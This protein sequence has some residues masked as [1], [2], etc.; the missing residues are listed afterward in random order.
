MQRVSYMPALLLAL[1]VAA[2]CQ[3]S[4][5]GFVSCRYGKHVAAFSSPQLQTPSTMLKCNEK[6]TV[7][8]VNAGLVRI[9]TKQGA[10]LYLTA[11]QLTPEK[12]RKQ[13]KG[14]WRS[15]A[16]A[17]AA[18]VAAYGNSTG[19]S[20]TSAHKI[21]IFGG[22]GH[23]TYLGCL[24]CSEYA[25]DSVTNS[26]GTH[27]S[28]YGSESIFNHYSEYGSAYSSYGAC[29]SYASDPPVIVDESG[30]YYGRLTLNTY[31]SEIASGRN[32]L[33]WLTAVC[34]D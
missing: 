15:F 21:M 32:F 18:G 2:Q 27:G 34:K 7:I 17:N 9:K 13:G 12:T 5:S 23:K 8:S 3:S 28:S 1:C 25:T 24:N 26:Y 16:E 14:F 20:T 19:A 4:N 11:D 30:T 33:S 31:H 22:E 10:E 29:N 6:V